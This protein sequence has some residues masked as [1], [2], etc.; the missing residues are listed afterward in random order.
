M[1]YLAQATRRFLDSLKGKS[2]LLVLGA[3]VVAVL[4]V[5]VI[6][7]WQG[8]A[9]LR[10]QVVASLEGTAAIV[11]QDIDNKLALRFSA[12]TRVARGINLGEAEL[13]L[14][15]GHLVQHDHALTALFDSVFI[16]GARG[17]VLAD[18]PERG[19]AGVSVAD[20]DYFA[21]MR[22]RLSTVVSEPVLSKVNPHP[23]VTIIAPLFGPQKRL[24]GAIAGSIDLD[25]DGFVGPLRNTPLGEGGFISMATRSGLT[26]SHPRIKEIL[27]APPDNVAI[28]H[29]LAGEEG[30]YT[31]RTLQG[32]KSLYAIRQL[33]EAP[34]F[35]AVVV[36]TRE[37]FKPFERFTE[38]AGLVALLVLLLVAPVAWWLS[39][40]FFR[41]LERLQRQISARHEGRRSDAVEVAGSLEVRAVA[42]AFNNV[43]EER[44]RVL[45]SLAERE[46]FFRSLTEDAPLGILHMDILG[47]IR[48][49]NE[50]FC[51]I[52]GFNL[53]VLSGAT[54]W[55][56]WSLRTEAT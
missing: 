55:M 36:P 15:A 35:V 14:Q 51:R 3:I 52:T 26:I 31:A 5:A 38:V 40:R 13:H 50:A 44:T 10:A 24:V 28:R 16:V 6:S 42:S 43:Y 47:R 19:R 27:K 56:A 48:F 49:A 39:G 7:L 29:A 17:T 9:L 32:V 23:V 12:L 4:V 33:G 37:A 34:W 11:Q 30:V 22:E 8:R 1:A 46:A 53:K 18:F 2:V 21:Q 45:A 25:R 54:G 20:R 41:P